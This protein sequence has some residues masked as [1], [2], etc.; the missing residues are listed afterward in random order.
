MAARLA[1]RMTDAT[2]LLRLVQW[3]SPGFPIGGFAYSQGLETAIAAGDV[4][5]AASL[6]DWITAILIFGSARSDAILIS[7]ARDGADL[8]DYALALAPS[9]E[10]HIEM[11]EQGRAFGRAIA[12]I[13]GTPQPVLP[14]SLALA[15]ASRNLN[16]PTNTVVMLWL[17]AAAAQLASVGV[18]F[19]PIGQ[20]DG[21]RIL[22]ALAPLI[23]RLAADCATAPLSDIGTA[24]IAADLASM[25]HETLP[26]RIYRT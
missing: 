18:R 19:I 2:D 17:Q 21:Q 14:Y 3:L 23:T 13:T 4:H 1:M 20:T 10:R 22:A 24:T 5:D 9:A 12:A 11:M 6:Q 26:V 16:I 25:Q 15:H 7:H 8:T